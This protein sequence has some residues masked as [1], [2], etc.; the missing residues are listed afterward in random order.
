MKNNIISRFSVLNKE[1]MKNTKAGSSL[2]AGRN[3]P[4]WVVDGVSI[5]DGV[6][7]NKDS[8]SSSS[9]IDN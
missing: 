7:T 9:K 3:R 6:S 8:T 5:S 2:S 4:L 1:Q